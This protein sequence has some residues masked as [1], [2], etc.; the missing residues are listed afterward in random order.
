M[1]T[2]ALAVMRARLQQVVETRDLSLVLH[3]E[4]VHQARK[5]ADLLLA[6]DDLEIRFVLGWFHWY[7]SLAL[8]A[9]EKD[10]KAAV[11]AFTPCFVAGLDNL[12]TPLLPYLADAAAEHA[13]AML[14]HA[15]LSPEPEQI[16]A[17]VDLWRRILL[18]IPADRPGRVGYQSNLGSALLMRFE[19]GGAGADLETAID[20]FRLA[21]KAT[22]V[23]HADRAGLVA[24][25]GIALMRRYE[26]RGGMHDLEAAIDHLR[27]AVE[28]SPPDDP[29]RGMYLSNLGAA[30][31]ARFERIGAVADLEAAV[32][33]LQEAVDT[34]PTDHPGRAVGFYNL[35]LALQRRVEQ[36]A[37]TAD[38]DAVIDCFTKAVEATA[39][40]HPERPAHLSS[41]GVALQGR[42]SRTGAEA[43]LDTSIDCFEKAVRA[44]S[45]GHPDRA[46]YLSNLG[47]ALQGR[48]SQSGADTDLESSIDCFE[49]AVQATPTD[50]PERA[51]YLSNLGAAL[52]TL[53]ERTGRVADLEAAI[54]HHQKAVDTTPTDHPD[55]GARL[56]NLGTALHTR[57]EWNGAV[58][59]LDSAVDRH[60]EAV[61]TT[62]VDH[63][64]RAAML[65]NLG[66]ALQAR[67]ERTGAVADLKTAVEHLQEAL[68]TTPT[69]HPSHAR[70]LSNLADARRIRY[71]R[72]GVVADLETAVQL[73]Q[74]AV[75]ATPADHPER[76][77]RL[78]NLGITLQARFERLAAGADLDKAVGHLQEA[79]DATPADDPS[80][81]RYLSNLGTALQTQFRQTGVAEVLDTAVERLHEAV[82]ATPADHPDRAPRLSNLGASLQARF[83]RTR[84]VKDLNAAVDAWQKALDADSAAPSIRVEAGI[85]AA[86]L[87]T[88]SGAAERAA[89]VTEAA[90][91]LLPQV[92]PRRLER[93]DQQHA[94]GSFAGLAGAAAARALAAPGGSAS[95]R[96][97]RA[98]GLLEAGRAVLLSQALDARSDL[99]D[100][101][102]RHPE[103]ARRF[104]EQRE[105]LDQPVNTKI[106]TRRSDAGESPRSGLENTARG[107]NRLAEQFNATL[108]EIRSLD[109]FASFALPPT[110]DELITEASHG[111][112][113]VFNVH[114]GRG[115]ALLLTAH[116][117]TSLELP[118]LIPRNVVE[119]INTFRQ[120][121]HRARSGADPSERE[122]AQET[123]LAVLRWLWDAAAGPVLEALGYDGQPAAATC[124][125]HEAGWPRVW[126]APGGLLGLLPLH[127][128]GYHSDAADDPHRR[129]VM[130]RVVSSYTPTVRALRYARER[131]SRQARETSAP[132]ALIVAM[133]T[134]PHVPGRLPF[135]DAEAAML[136]D[137]LP[138]SVVL[139]EPDPA[140]APVDPTPSTPTK[141]NVL[142]HLPRCAIAHFACHGASHPTD[143]SKSRLL[144][145]DHKDDPLTVGSLAPVALD[146]ARLAYLSACRT[147]AIDTT[148]LLDEA[149]HLTS[150]FQLAGYPHVIGTLWEID[151]RIA[152]RIAKAFYEGLRSDS[153]ALDADQAARALHEAVRRVRDGRDLPPGHD[154]TRSPY[155][156]A[157]HLHAGA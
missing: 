26:H 127:A 45:T 40:G 3:A 96:A 75:D 39:P 15:R 86:D 43:D 8:R 69:D 95:E 70:Y 118:R 76:A 54:R 100:L 126:W 132:A 64:D 144:L 47:A 36:N 139:R 157:A 2:E 68:D 141:A 33:R 101:N 114:T 105:R 107:R 7:R 11:Q 60:R 61:Q 52:E 99:T 13:Y 98:L 128:A 12:P 23:G 138:D 156:W 42:F 16:S 28:A 80:R 136:Q 129:T 155:V 89:D 67:F 148:S 153:A 87:L 88:K 53:A 143:P 30:L 122:E 112:V 137:R 41:L 22:P 145:H 123:L 6:Q 147:A 4:A 29:D 109:G 63:S 57:F 120:A 24:N 104:A 102:E 55:R 108:A 142:A 25:L 133:P 85:S 31:R 135:V 94:I 103:L 93:G 9:G 82:E 130:D 91:R 49:K 119:T 10:L 65:S 18:T 27:K 150:A 66:I 84:K 56:T 81:A 83:E 35:G 73:H 124:G 115:D 51:T 14:E 17:A 111:P 140:D 110:V 44:T 151:D 32:G 113:V 5:L 46:A 72:T 131:A 134:T 92:V 77:P 59:D 1:R 58:A 74:Q 154:R 97:E 38:F 152:V 79:V 34:T 48:F 116:G 50:H 117:I 21:M 20:C 146:Q 78:S 62:P 106:S 121:L 71:M 149:I 125:A 90:V 19:W 37:A